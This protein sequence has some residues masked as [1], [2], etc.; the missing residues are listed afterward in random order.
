LLRPEEIAELE[1]EVE[2]MP[3][4]D[5]ACIEA[6]KVVQ[7]H[8]GWV[9]DEGLRD[10][11]TYLEMD[12]AQVESVATFYNL[13]FR[14]PVGRHVILMCDSVSCWMLGY[15][16]LRRRLT[17]TL[18]ID[19]GETTADDRFTLLP[20][21]CLGNCDHA[22]ALMVDEDLHQDLVPDDLPGILED[23]E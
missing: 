20:I 10:V 18:G 14:Q 11:A 13:I 4:K 5:A 19:L 9:T 6:L 7:R 17:E 12:P 2:A 15:D 16:A 1:G 23:Y 8:R 22:P 21:P 3:R